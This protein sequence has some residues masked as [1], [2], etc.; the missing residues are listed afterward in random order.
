MNLGPSSEEPEKVYELIAQALD[1]LGLDKEALF[2]K[3]AQSC[4]KR[5]SARMLEEVQQAIGIA[6]ES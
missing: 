3:Q 6:R 1:E 5:R 2:L 4:L